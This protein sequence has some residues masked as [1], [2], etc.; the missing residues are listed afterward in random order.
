MLLFLKKLWRN[1]R[2]TILVFIGLFI[3]LIGLITFPLPL[4]L[5]LPLLIISAIILLRNSS[6]AR[7]GFRRLKKWVATRPKLQIIHHF[8]KKIESLVYRQKM[9]FLNK[10]Q[11]IVEKINKIRS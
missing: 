10:K 7:L 2:R 4:P 8:L 1:F 9:N 6:R 11:A 3:L 5:G